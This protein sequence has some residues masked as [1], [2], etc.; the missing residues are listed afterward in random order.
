MKKSQL[1]Q[2]IRECVI[3][4]NEENEE[5]KAMDAIKGVMFKLKKEFEPVLKEMKNKQLIKDYK[6]KIKPYN[7]GF[8]LDF[9]MNT[10]SSRNLRDIEEQ[11]EEL[12]KL[13]WS[14]HS[15]Y[16][17]PETFFQEHLDKG[18][19]AKFEGKGF[20]EYHNDHEG[21]KLLDNSIFKNIK[22]KKDIKKAVEAY[23]KENVKRI[24]EIKKYVDAVE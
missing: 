2:I 24:K 19:S 13:L 14:L 12:I 9:N 8:K 21:F 23:Y 10:K 1:K 16:L 18:E 6:Q 20:P 17:Y 3:E 11:N 4:L 15:V 22:D 7:S 5:L